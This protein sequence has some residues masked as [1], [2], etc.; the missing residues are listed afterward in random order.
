[1]LC[2]YGL[3]LLFLCSICISVSVIFIPFNASFV[4]CVFSFFVVS[5]FVLQLSSSALLNGCVRAF[6][7][8]SL[9]NFLA[10]FYMFRRTYFHSLSNTHLFWISS[11]LF[12]MS[13][14]IV[15]YMLVADIVAGVAI[16][17]SPPPSSHQ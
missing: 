10:F 12:D 13:S 17:D 8:S 16:N 5:V 4:V 7:F 9:Y 11:I 1:M 14:N 6:D 3:A 15:I 2:S